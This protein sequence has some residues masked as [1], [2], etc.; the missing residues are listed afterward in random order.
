MKPHREGSTRASDDS[1]RAPVIE[2][3]PGNE[4]QDLP[5]LFAETAQRLQHRALRSGTA[6][7][8]GSVDRLG[9]LRGRDLGR[10][11]GMLTYVRLR[12][13]HYAHGCDPAEERESRHSGRT[14]RTSVM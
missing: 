6:V 10:F 3:F 2:A 9:S 5:I 12:T 14:C 8:D 7:G 11:S 4:K 1:G 13:G